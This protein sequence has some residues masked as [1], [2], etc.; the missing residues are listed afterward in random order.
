MLYLIG[1]TARTG[2]STVA[3]RFLAETGVPFFCLD[4]LMMGF[5]NGLPEYGID[6]DDDEL[7]VGE[8]LWPVVKPLATAMVE[9]NLDYLLE[10]VQ[11]NPRHA[12]QLYNQF[13]GQVRVC[14]LGFAHVDIMAKFRQLRQFSGGENDWL[15]AYDDAKTL[16]EVE[17]LKALSKRLQ[18]ECDAC[19]LQYFETTTDLEQTVVTVV[20]Y[21]KG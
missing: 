2:K 18:R 11:L 3:R 13:E 10:G 20:R 19:G 21:L 9:N 1:G 17:R 5:A 4:Y 12:W 16:R 15:K 14:F 8:L 6:P 7:H